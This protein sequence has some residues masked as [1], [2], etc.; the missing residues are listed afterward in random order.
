MISTNKDKED[1]GTSYDIDVGDL[2]M[3]RGNELVH[4]RPEYK[5]KWQA[6]VFFHYVD[7]NGKFANHKGDRLNENNAE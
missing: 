6:Q 1:P 3:Y 7:A 4:W 5:G 2:V